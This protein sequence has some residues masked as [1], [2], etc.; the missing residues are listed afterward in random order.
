MDLSF[1]NPAGF[2]ALLGIPAILL[3][4]FLQ[5]EARR[6]VTST[7][8]LLEQLN[9]V[10]AQGR[11]FE[12][13]RNSV[14]LWLQLLA[15]L[16]LTWL[17]VQPR[18]LRK[19]S[20]QSVVI[21]LD[22]SASMQVFRER[23][24]AALRQRLASFARTAGRTE[25]VLIESDPARPTLYSGGDLHALFPALEKW[26][27]HLGTHDFAPALRVAR[28]LLRENGV[29]LFVTDRHAKLPEGVELFA[30]GEPLDNCGFIGGH[31][32]SKSWRV[33][34]KNHG[35]AAQTRTWSVHSGNSTT[36]SKELM[37]EP[38][39]THTLEGIF[40]DDA[41]KC[42]LV[43]SGDRFA[44]DDRLPMVRPKPKRLNVAVE[45]GTSLDPFFQRFTTSIANAEL[46]SSDADLRLTVYNPLVPLPSTN[47]TIVFLSDRHE[48]KQFLPGEIV[49]ENHPLNAD[50]SWQGL[51]CR[52]A[53]SIP[54]GE[55][56]EV[57][58]WQGARPLLFIHRSGGNRCLIVNLDLNQ[59]NADR[60]PAFVVLLHRFTEA[61]RSAKIAPEQLNFETNQLLTV[62][63]DPAGP[64][65]A[66][67]TSKPSSP[68]PMLRAPT[69]PG[70][71][72]VT[73]GG[74]TLLTG[75]AHF[76]DSRE[77]DFREALSADGLDGRISSL[78]ERNSRHDFFTPLWALFLGVVCLANWALIGKPDKHG[79]AEQ[80]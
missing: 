25:W 11:R 31:F 80:A 70:F 65:P 32:E 56:A 68:A 42:E 54:A 23:M 53:L 43:L 46:T 58:V 3:I 29:A 35:R 55:E 66:L 75:A 45:P 17:L 78:I 39:Q 30:I 49:A 13:I 19:D 4:H 26:T 8:F 52:E 76:A 34:V 62:A 21:V 6:V 1:A 24:V 57:L 9:P 64:P 22:S 77:A 40:P 74:S 47:G 71:F 73:Q 63:S 72:A 79:T 44:L 2:W 27:P 60:L 38:G 7:L 18:W 36:P 12:R 14:P 5:R 61:I 48:A 33:L 67:S 16:L 69:E 50:L 10:S 59:S 15:V 37:L 41:D 20:A 28:S 51:L